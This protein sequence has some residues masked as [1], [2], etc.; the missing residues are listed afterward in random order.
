MKKFFADILDALMTAAQV[1][2][3]PFTNLVNK[4]KQKRDISAF[5]IVQ[6]AVRFGIWAA[7]AFTLV[8]GGSIGFVLGSLIALDVLYMFATFH[9]FGFFS[10]LMKT[11]MQA[12]AEAANKA[13]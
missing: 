10:A 4:V 11:A 7:L 8:T 5:D 9:L 3:F 2:I 1:F 13:E 6:A 12:M